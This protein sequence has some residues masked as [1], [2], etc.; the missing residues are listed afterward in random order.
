MNSIMINLLIQIVKQIVG[1]A[2]F[3]F[4]ANAVANAERSSDPGDQKR[5]AVVRSV[6]STGLAQQAAGWAINLAVEA[7]VARLKVSK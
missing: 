5:A 4:I 3:A 7:A 1:G 6:M 2:L